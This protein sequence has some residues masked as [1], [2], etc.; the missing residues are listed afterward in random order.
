MPGLSSVTHN[1]SLKRCALRYDCVRNSG[2]S[3]MAL[4]S[5]DIV[6]ITEA[7]ARLA[8]LADE[9]VREGSEKI[10]TRNGVAQVALIDAKRLDYY[11]ALEAQQADLESLLEAQR[12]LEDMVAGRTLSASELR[13]RLTAPEG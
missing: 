10:L 3:L 9:V 5:V 4:R 2:V 13:H 6:P 11:H 12:G 7:R 1:R 8:E